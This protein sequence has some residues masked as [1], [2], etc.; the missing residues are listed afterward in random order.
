MWIVFA[1]YSRGTLRRD[2][3]TPI[4]DADPTRHSNAGRRCKLGCPK[5][6]A[7]TIAETCTVQ[8]GPSCWRSCTRRSTRLVG[9]SFSTVASVSGRN[10]A[11]ASIAAQLAW[12]RNSR[13]GWPRRLAGP[14]RR[15]VDWLEEQIDSKRWEPA[16]IERTFKTDGTEHLQRPAVQTT[17]AYF[18]A[19]NPWRS[20]NNVRTPTSANWRAVKA[21]PG[22]APTITTSQFWVAACSS[23]S[24]PVGTSV[25]PREQP[26]LGPMKG[27]RRA[28][29]TVLFGQLADFADR[30]GGGDRPWSINMHDM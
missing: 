24:V 7:A 26:P 22:P 18:I 19:G 9:S 11:P 4:F 30:K 23:V 27:D 5:P 21:P 6:S 14:T 12:R 3:P 16:R 13:V 28:F 20:T 25:A 17:T 1:R 2:V 15:G 29:Q 8:L 10:S